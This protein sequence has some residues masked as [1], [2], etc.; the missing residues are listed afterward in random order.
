MQESSKQSRQ[1]DVAGSRLRPLEGIRVLDLSR[2]LAGPWCTQNLA[3][4]GARVIK[5]ERPGAGDETRSW[6]PPFLR[7]AGGRDT[8]ESAYYLCANRNKQSVAIDIGSPE[9]AALVREFAKTCD[10][11]VENFKVGGLKKYGLDYESLAEL[12]PRLV[13]CSVTG[14]GQTG[15][16]SKRAGY[17][18]LVQGMGGLMSITGEPDDIPGGGP[19]KVGVAVTDLMAGMY[20]TTGV[21]A[22]LMERARSGRGQHVDIALLD[23]QLAML[24]N[25]SMNYLTTGI[26]P[27]RLGNAHPN[28]VPYQTFATNN[29]HLILACG[30]DGQFRALCGAMNRPELATDVRFATNSARS[31]NRADL[32]PLLASLF[33]TRSNDEWITTLEACGVP[34]GPINDIAQAFESEQARHRNAVRHMAHPLAGS[35]PTVTSP[36]RLSATPVEYVQPPPLL[37]EHTAAVLHDLLGMEPAQIAGLSQAGVIGVPFVA[38]VHEEA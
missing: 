35:A 27:R 25:Q 3:D 12:N 29:G 7:D 21:L 4:L 36:L 13:Y 15:P 32:I 34:C 20:A 14:F 38:D 16:L 30:N 22:A 2:V 9:G 17:D 33:A 11:L 26:A 31:V 18:F 23:C 19:E 8:S 24:A 5:I 1:N 28:V 6:G 37:G 10:V